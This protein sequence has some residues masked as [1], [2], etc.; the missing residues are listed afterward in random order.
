M[1]ADVRNFSQRYFPGKTIPPTA[2]G[3]SW[4]FCI[5]DP[6]R[7]SVQ[8]SASSGPADKVKELISKMWGC[9]L[10]SRA[11]DPSTG[12]YQ[13]RLRDS[14]TCSGYPWYPNY[15]DGPGAAPMWT[16]PL[17]CKGF[18]HASDAPG[19]CRR[20]AD[21]QAYCGAVA[22]WKTVSLPASQVCDTSASGMSGV[23]DWS[24]CPPL[25]NVTWLMRIRGFP[26]SNP[27]TG[28]FVGNA[29]AAVPALTSYCA[30]CNI[31]QPNWPLN[32][33]DYPK[34]C[35]VSAWAPFQWPFF[36]GP[37]DCTYVPVDAPYTVLGCTED[38][39]WDGSLGGGR[40]VFDASRMAG[41]YFGPRV[42]APPVDFAARAAPLLQLSCDLTMTLRLHK[43]LG[44]AIA[45]RELRNVFD[46]AADKVSA[47]FWSVE[48]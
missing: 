1:K 36:Q 29:D 41:D 31:T 45:M 5:P 23:V 22:T 14:Q 38:P 9:T 12:C 33:A 13:L 46:F 35:N 42:A 43:R 18:G 48:S 24:K 39:A 37:I 40:N 15:Y 16:G 28:W 34:P 44:L 11:R 30:R 21:A 10:A 7:L 3:S 8:N 25:C 2:L 32:W 26:S 17:A 27:G 6:G 4:Q 47:P 19:Q 20:L